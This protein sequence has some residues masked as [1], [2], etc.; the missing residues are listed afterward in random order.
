MS[1]LRRSTR[2]LLALLPH[3]G[4]G[5]TLDIGSEGG[6]VAHETG[7]TYLHVSLVG[8]A[9]AHAAG[10][11]ALHND[12][13]PAGPFGTICFDAHDYEPGFAAETVCQAASR[14]TADGVLLTTARRADVEAA[15]RQVEEHGEALVARGPVAVPE[16]PPPDRPVVEAEFGGETC[17]LQSAPGVFSPRR[18]DDG[19]AFML[20]LLKP[21]P[22]ARFLDLGCGIGIVSRIATEQWGC[23]VTAVDVNAR[24]L[25][26]TSVNAPKAEVL[27]SDGFGALRGRTFDLIA[28]NP[29]YHVDFSVG[30]A[31]IEGAHAHLATG[32]LLALVVKRADWYVQKVRT[33][34]GGCRIETNGEYTVILTEKREPRP[35]KAAPAAPATTK[36]HEKRMALTKSKRRH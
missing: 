20:G 10:V 18:M 14:L 1:D 3:G 24:A 32:G 35:A 29:P 5:P 9:A 30:R 26:L 17:R 36:K 27:A 31:F 7:G 28:S 2:H 16:L 33:V 19:T 22:G 11:S 25:R 8:A 12:I 23:E 13:L 15:F 21:G 4:A 6:A 34:F